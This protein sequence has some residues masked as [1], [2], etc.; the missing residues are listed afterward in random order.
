MH[1]LLLEIAYGGH[2]SAFNNGKAEDTAARVLDLE[3]VVLP[4]QVHR[5]ALEVQH[6]LRHVRFRPQR[7]R[8]TE[9][10]IRRV[11]GH[12]GK[13]HLRGERV[14]DE[15]VNTRRQRRHGRAGVDDRSAGPVL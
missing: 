12:H 8:Q 5:R 3:H 14:T 11:A 4:G 13:L 2:L 6:Q 7:R 1:V 10:G 15:P 9:V